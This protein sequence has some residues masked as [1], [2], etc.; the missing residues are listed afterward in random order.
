M[1]AA[2]DADVPGGVGEGDRRCKGV[3]AAGTPWTDQWFDVIPTWAAEKGDGVIRQHALADGALN[4]QNQIHQPS[5]DLA[6]VRQRGQCRTVHRVSRDAA[7]VVRGCHNMYV[8]VLGESSC[9]H[10]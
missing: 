9:E 4:G 2:G 5:D 3:S 8:I 7:L 6:D 10:D 1:Q